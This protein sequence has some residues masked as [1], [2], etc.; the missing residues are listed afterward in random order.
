MF[1]LNAVRIGQKWF[2]LGREKVPVRLRF[3]LEVADALFIRCGRF[4]FVRGC[5]ESISFTVEGRACCDS[6][7]MMQGQSGSDF[8]RAIAVE[9]SGS[10]LGVQ[11]GQASRLA[12][13]IGKARG[14]RPEFAIRIEGW[15]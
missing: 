9:Q 12:P 8:R 4:E 1:E 15:R 10:H 13:R 14:G 2:C 5:E 3:R 7:W 6:W 11:S